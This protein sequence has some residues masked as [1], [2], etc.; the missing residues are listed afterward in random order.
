[1]TIVDFIENVFRALEYAVQ[2]LRQLAAGEATSQAKRAGKMTTPDF[3]RF[4]RDR[5]KCKINRLLDWL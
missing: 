1:M 5:A 2:L 3:L 4:P